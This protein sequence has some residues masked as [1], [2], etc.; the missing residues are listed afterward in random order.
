M[1]KQTKE[2]MKKTLYI[3]HGALGA[4][5][6]LKPLAELLSDN[7]N[8]ITLDFEGH[9]LG[10]E[11][12]RPYRMEYFAENVINLMNDNNIDKCSIFGYSMGGYV[13]LYCAVKYPEKIESVITLGTK[14]YWTPENAASEIKKLN[15]DI[16]EQKIPVFAEILKKRHEKH[17]WRTL[18]EKTAEMMTDL[19]NNPTLTEND[20]REITAKLCIG[21]ADKDNMVSVEETAQLAS[22]NEKAGFYVL[23]HSLHP[24]EKVNNEILSQIIRQFA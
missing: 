6:Q 10:E 23:P 4:A 20:V 19:G 14:F 2:I 7:Y 5:E 13:G 18:L 21:V 16:I 8:I 22:T 9:G 15:P 24:I 3:L 11:V 1:E 17:T 12:S